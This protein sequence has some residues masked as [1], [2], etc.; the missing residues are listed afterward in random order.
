MLMQVMQCVWGWG[1][2]LGAWHHQESGATPSLLTP[3]E[4]RYLV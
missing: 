1:A 4:H 2:E 3:A